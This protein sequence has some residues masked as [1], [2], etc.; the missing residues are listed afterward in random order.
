[1]LYV[2]IGDNI[3][4]KKEALTKLLKNHTECE[5]FYIKDEA[6]DPEV[7]AN[8]IAG[9]DL[10]A[11]QYIVVIDSLIDTDAGD[12]VLGKT[13]EMEKSANIFVVLETAILKDATTVLKKAAEAFESFD[14]PKS[15]K[16]KFN[17]FSITDSFGARDKKNTW[18]LLQQALREGV[19][20]DEVLN[21]LIWQTK[22]LLFAKRSTDMKST[23]L[24]PFVYN[25]SKQ[26]SANYKES[27]LVDM[28]RELIKFFH[29]SHLGL[30][31]APN[32]EAYLLKT[33]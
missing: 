1:M 3:E 13:V 5:I 19:A 17:I 4:K 6:F 14:L 26:Y 16:A 8:F 33:L 18:V 23:G 11:N 21:I 20:A 12:I 32:L 9:G 15:V 7:F 31:L 30:E 2:Y 10:F 29:E 28:S 24:S 27:E 22:N 25:K